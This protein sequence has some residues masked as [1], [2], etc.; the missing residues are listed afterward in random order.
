MEDERREEIWYILSLICAGE[1]ESVRYNELT[2]IDLD[3]IKEIF[4]NEVVLYWGPQYMSVT[5][6]MGEGVSREEIATEIRAKLKCRKKS[7]VARL[8]NKC[9]APFWRYLFRESWDI[10]VCGWKKNRL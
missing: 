10:F 8:I 1:T 6:P 2:G 5:P 3:Q 7:I 4:F 9:C